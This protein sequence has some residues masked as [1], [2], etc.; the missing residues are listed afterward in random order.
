MTNPLERILLADDDVEYRSAIAN[1]LFSY[2]VD[3]ALNANEAIEKTKNNMYALIILDNN[4]EDGYGDSGIYA[5]EQIRR[6]DTKT[7]IFLHTADLTDYI[8]NSALRLGANDVFS[9]MI[10]VRELKEKIKSCKTARLD[11]QSSL[12]L[13]NTQ[14]R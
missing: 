13:R 1:A 14:L 9:K 6:F 5:I 7:P 10:S 3:L 8:K 12:I 2:D 4:M 11:H